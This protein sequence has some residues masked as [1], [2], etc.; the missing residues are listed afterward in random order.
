MKYAVVI[1]EDAQR[2]VEEI[3]QYIEATDS[4]AA[5]NHVLN[6]LEQLILGRTSIRSVAIFPKNLC[7]SG[8]VSIGKSISNPTLLY[9]G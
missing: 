1:T 5:A 7:R 9:T 2:D 8:F 6:R 3:E 4:V